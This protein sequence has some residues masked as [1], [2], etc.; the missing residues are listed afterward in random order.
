MLG[1]Y[2]RLSSFT[3]SLPSPGGE[4][5]ARGARGGMLSARWEVCLQLQVAKRIWAGCVSHTSPYIRMFMH[6]RRWFFANLLSLWEAA[7]REH[8]C[9]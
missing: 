4:G 6:K 7:L 8:E 3:G 1:N 5:E 2:P 9:C